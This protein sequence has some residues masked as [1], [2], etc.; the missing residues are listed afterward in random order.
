MAGGGRKNLAARSMWDAFV[1]FLIAKAGTILPLLFAAVMAYL[2]AVSKWLNAYGPV[3]WGAVGITTFLVVA[4]S[5]WIVVQAQA[6]Y[7]Q[8]RFAKKHEE[9][10]GINP[11]DDHFTRQRINLV[12]FFHPF[13]KPTRLAKFQDCELFGPAVIALTGKSTLH[14]GEFNGCEVVI[15]KPEVTVVG[16][17]V[18][19]NCTFERCK[20]FRVTFLLSKDQ[21]R[22]M[23]EQVKGDRM[24]VISD[25]TAGEL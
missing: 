5:W 3:A 8:T 18:F 9:S 10:T 24:S 4:V 16:A 17:T 13:Y 22:S 11:L 14:T 12:D 23:T 15:I 19:E 7:V 20:F 21:Y 25:G 2:A 1:D 6:R